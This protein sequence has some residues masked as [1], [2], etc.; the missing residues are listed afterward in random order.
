MKYKALQVIMHMLLSSTV[1]VDNN[2]Q[3]LLLQAH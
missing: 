1:S 3:Q 2:L